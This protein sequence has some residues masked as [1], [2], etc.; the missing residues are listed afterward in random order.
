MG[1]ILV[2]GEALVDVVVRPDGSTSE[3]P[4]GSP[5]NVAL[6][7]ARLG[8]PTSLL[9]ALGDDARG[10][11][12]LDHLGASGVEVVEGSVQPGLTS[13]ATATLA[14]DGQASY[15]FDLRWELGDAD[16]PVEPV[17]VHT[18]SIGAVLSPGGATVERIVRAARSASTTSYDPNLRPD[19]MGSP[20]AVLP[21]VEALVGASDVVK[22]SDEDAEWLVPGVPVEELAAQ[23]LQ[24]GP[25]VVVVTMGGSGMYGLC[26]AG[27][28]SVQAPRVDVADT[29][30]AG[31]SAMAA[32]LDGLWEHDLLGAAAR[33]A[34]TAISTDVLEQVVRHAVT[35]AA[36]T[37]SR[38]GA[39]P[40]T[41]ADLARPARRF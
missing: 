38:P 35:A 16:L 26:R 14:E 21:L 37:V 25:A 15:V 22:L 34:L 29:V 9:T 41:R 17:A 10:R 11:A 8:R 32:L 24:R 6:G 33:E 5:A 40:P 28:V 4:G 19:L 27:E 31:D 12:V 2:V 18:G 39:D 36:I 30:G 23:W 7:L 3:H 20:E 1:R 13:V